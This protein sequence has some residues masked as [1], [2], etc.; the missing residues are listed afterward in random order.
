MPKVSDE[1]REARRRQIVEA[2]MRS[3][4]RSGFQGSS[5]SDIIAESGLSTGAIYGHFAG[6][7]EIVSAVAIEVLEGGLSE[8]KEAR[9]PDG[10]PTHPLDF[11]LRLVTSLT[12]RV[13]GTALPVQIWG[14]AV[15][16]PDLRELFGTILPEIVAAVAEQTALWLHEVRG[17]GDEQ[18]RTRAEHLAPLV[19]GMLQ[20]AVIQSELLDEFDL[21]AYLAPARPLFDGALDDRPSDVVA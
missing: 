20:G 15:V 2:A 3:F 14:R 18:A 12:G 16:D 5:M 8:M 10:A 21:A 11:V 4:L 1:H 6:K 7:S 19:T 17:L 9:D 13:G